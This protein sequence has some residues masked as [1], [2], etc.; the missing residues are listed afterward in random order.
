M[1]VHPVAVPARPVAR[2]RAVVGDERYNR[3]VTAAGGFRERLAGRTVWNVNSTATGGGVA[4]ML[5]QLVA[6][7]A[8]AGI[9]ARWSVL[10]GDEAFFAITKRVH[11]FLHGSTGDGGR[12]DEPEH[13][14][15]ESVLAEN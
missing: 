3:L 14:H 6:Y 2:L 8:G 11:N 15:Y 4:E 9:A 10:E 13:R 12:L 5:E 1:M 7:A